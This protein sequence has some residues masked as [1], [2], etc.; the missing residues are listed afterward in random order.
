MEDY[1]AQLEKQEEEIIS[2]EVPFGEK[3]RMMKE[4]EVLMGDL[5]RME[6][7]YMERKEEL[8]RKKEGK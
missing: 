4:M 6:K 5:K 8:E 7:N 1:K 3:D 2:S